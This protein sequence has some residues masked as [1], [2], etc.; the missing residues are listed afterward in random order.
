M[1]TNFMMQD[2]VITEIKE[3]T[4]FYKKDIQMVMDALEDIII[5]HMHTATFEQ[6]AEMRLFKGWRMGAK[7]TPERESIDPRD[8][9]TIVTPEKLIPHCKFKQSFRD[10]MNRQDRMSE[11]EDNEE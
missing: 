2:D 8:R 11:V 9:S 7:R 10:R 3:R 6:P 4:G 5:E 1:I